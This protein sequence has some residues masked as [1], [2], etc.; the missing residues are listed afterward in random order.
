LK[1]KVHTLSG[2]KE[3]RLIGIASHLSDYKI[4]WLFNEELN[5]KLNHSEDITD[6]SN[7]NEIHKFTTYK[8]EVERDL[9]YTLISNRS[10][11]SVLVRAHKNLDFIL[12]IEG[13]ISDNQLSNLIEKI[14]K[15]K[16]ILTAFE[17][18]KENLKIKEIDLLT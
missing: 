12:K 17:V 5:F 15:L 10:E 14:K 16:N 7:K 18:E 11:M 6:S 8:Y 4:S 1:A 13:T 3:F 2:D 9:L